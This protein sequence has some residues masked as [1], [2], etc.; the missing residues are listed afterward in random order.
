MALRDVLKRRLARVGLAPFVPGNRVEVLFDGGPFFG[1]LLDE[2]VAAQRYV[3]LE[4]YIVVADATGWKVAHALADRARAGVEV[5]LILDAYGSLTLDPG[6]VTFLREAGVK[7]LIF[8]PILMMTQRLPFWRR[9]NHRKLLVAD[10]HVGI[11]GGMNISDDYAAIEDGGHG[12]HDCAVRIEGPAVATL[13]AMFRTLWRESGGPDLESVFREGATYPEGDQVR[14]IANF[15][16]RDRAYVRRAYL[17]AFLAAEKTIRIM[18]AYFIPDRVLLRSLI[19]AARRGVRVEVI[20]A[21]ATDIKSIYYAT[22]SL[23]SKMLRNGI[24]VYEWEERVLHAKIAVVDGA[25]STIGST[26]LDHFSSFRNLEVNAGILGER[27]GGELDDQ[28]A[29]DRARSKKIDFAAWKKRP[30]W[31]KVVEWWCGLFRKLL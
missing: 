14:F 18:N 8:R 24:E 1:R 22:R 25:W 17:L 13:E 26:N 21:A 15:A 30:F 5:A 29:V 19:R 3:F 12:W 7:V 10:G 31:I 16:R 9:R 28:F 20:V 4:S 2:I 23:Y 11:V 6:F 27:I